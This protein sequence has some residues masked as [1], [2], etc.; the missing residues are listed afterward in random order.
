MNQ[1]V[2]KNEYSVDTR[3]DCNLNDEAKCPYCGHDETDSWELDR[4]EECT[5]NTCGACDKE[6]NVTI[7]RSVTYST[8][9]MDDEHD[10]VVDNHHIEDMITCERCG[11]SQFLRHGDFKLE[12][13]KFIKVAEE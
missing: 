3:F 8:S 9:C 7:N 4:D 5:T 1:E 12:D 2:K 6:Y 13:G 11:D 10:Y